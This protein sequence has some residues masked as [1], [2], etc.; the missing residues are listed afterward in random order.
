[1]KLV[2]VE[3]RGTVDLIRSDRLWL[4]TRQDPESN[5]RSFFAQGVE[6]KQISSNDS[7]TQLS[8]SGAVD[9]HRGCR[10]NLSKILRAFIGVAEMIPYARNEK[11]NS[12][13]GQAGQCATHFRNGQ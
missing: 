13:R 2:P 9:R 7:I 1:M 8:V 4:F 5:L 11:Y 12:I 10:S 6:A 3:Q